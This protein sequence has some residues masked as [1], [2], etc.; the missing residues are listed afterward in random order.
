VTEKAIRTID[1]QAARIEELEL[2]QRQDEAEI[3]RLES[4]RFAP[5]ERAVLAACA[6]MRL[7]PEKG[8]RVRCRISVR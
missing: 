1:A 2:C 3:R 7:I 6:E 5:A 4:A 8:G